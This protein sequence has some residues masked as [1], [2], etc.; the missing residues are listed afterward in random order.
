MPISW[1]LAKQAVYRMV[2]EYSCA[3][4]NERQDDFQKAWKDVDELMCGEVSRTQRAWYMETPVLIDERVR[5]RGC[6][7]GVSLSIRKHPRGGGNAGGLHHHSISFDKYHPGDFRKVGMRHSHLKKNQ[8]YCPTV[9]LD[10]LWTLVSEQTGIDAAKSK[11]GLAPILGVVPAGYCKVLGKGKV[12][13][14]PVIVKAKFFSR[15]AEEKIKGVGGACVLVAENQCYQRKQV[16]L[17]K[18]KEN[19]VNV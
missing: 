1:R 16:S 8:S 3:V 17:L 9:N 10:K 15:R 5:R 6:S 7:V 18:I 4:R 19:Q 12:P 2:R 14:Q 11:E 13:K